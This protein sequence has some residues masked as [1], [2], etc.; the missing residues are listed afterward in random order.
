M[1]SS[2]LARTRPATL[3]RRVWRMLLRAFI[4]DSPLFFVIGLYAATAVAL[5]LTVGVP[6]R[7]TLRP[8]LGQ[9]KLHVVSTGLLATALLLGYLV[10]EV[11]VRHNSL[12]E[13][14][15]WLNAVR[16]TFPP[17]R[18][19]S[20][21]LII[22]ALPTLSRVFTTFKISIVNFVS[23][24]PWDVRFMHWDWLL[25]L[26]YHPW[27]LLQPLIGYPIMTKG[28][29][30]VYYL[31]FPVLWMTLIWQAWHGSRESDT[32]SQFLLAFALCWTLLGSL[33]ATVL[34]SAGPVYF[35]HVTDVISPYADQLQYL[36]RVDSIYD[37]NSVWAHGALW[38][39]Y[40]NGD[41]TEFSGISAMPSLHVS[42]ATLLAILGFNID[43]RLGW[44][45]SAFAV[46]I[47]LGSVHL[48]W[49]YALDGYVAV[50]ATWIIWRVSGLIVARVR[51]HFGIAGSG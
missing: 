51:N 10:N 1:E 18:T 9:W 43:R 33:A 3:G 32:R 19:L 24:G 22:L 37:L 30:M 48:A 50:V 12:Y 23:F 31:W 36:A 17:Y 20:Y 35:T 21:F 6:E 45:Y 39:S 16:R 42:M 15:P 44:L 28:L 40:V 27:A 46:A 25:H 26:G 7:V 49:H 41:P 47:F 5:H 4:E 34:S 14:T 13:R 11:M 2:V 38:D 8:S 29:D